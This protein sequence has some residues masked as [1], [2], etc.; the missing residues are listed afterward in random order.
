MNKSCHTNERHPTHTYTLPRLIS[1]TYPPYLFLQNWRHIPQ[2]KEVRGY[3]DAGYTP[4]VSDVTPLYPMSH[5]CIRCHTFVSDVTPLYPMSHLCI[6][7]HT[8]V[9]GTKT[10]ASPSILTTHCR[11][12]RK[13][14]GIHMIESRVSRH[15]HQRVMAHTDAYTHISD[16]KGTLSGPYC[17]L[18]NWGKRR[19]RHMN[20]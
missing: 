9:S 15:A 1:T 20:E 11:H 6:R 12:S 3:I 13:R 14:R 7:C 8:F 2:I 16:T 17:P 19:G 5:L 18:Q 4:T 10:D